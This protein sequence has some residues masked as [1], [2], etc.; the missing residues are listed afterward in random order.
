MLGALRSAGRRR[1]TGEALQ[2]TLLLLLLPSSG[3][4]QGG[5]WDGGSRL[6]AHPGSGR[7]RPVLSWP[8][9]GNTWPSAGR[10]AAFFSL[11]LT[12]SFGSDSSGTGRER[13]LAACSK[14]DLSL[15]GLE[16]NRGDARPFLCVQE[17][18]SGYSLPEWSFLSFSSQQNKHF[19]KSLL[20]KTLVFRE[21]CIHQQSFVTF[22]PSLLN[23]PPASTNQERGRKCP[24]H[25]ACIVPG[26]GTE[27]WAAPGSH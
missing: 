2:P 26:P 14:S 7:G 25:G 24:V 9:R 20:Y 10:G 21:K 8:T 4:R 22:P 13:W 6:A 19:I 23:M 12:P 16:V 15:V 5:G 11:C 17:K 27:G 3:R 1:G 18:K